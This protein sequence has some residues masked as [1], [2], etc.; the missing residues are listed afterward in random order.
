MVLFLFYFIFPLFPPYIDKARS[1]GVL[2]TERSKGREEGKPLGH[3]KH[4]M[5]FLG[6]EG[7]TQASISFFFL[8][9]YWFLFYPPPSFCVSVCLCALASVW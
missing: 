3:R 1:N 4:C 5:V 8:F 6:G 9:L 2:E 7:Y